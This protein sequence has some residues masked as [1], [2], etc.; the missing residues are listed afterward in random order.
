[1]GKKKKKKKLVM[2]PGGRA[3][4]ILMVGKIGSPED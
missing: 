4:A 3:D 2:R 1:M